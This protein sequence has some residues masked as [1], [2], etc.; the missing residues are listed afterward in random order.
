VTA[1]VDVSHSS[2]N[3]HDPTIGISDG[4]SFIGVIVYDTYANPCHI[5]EGDS[6]TTILKNINTINSPT[7]TSQCYFSEIKIQ[8]RP[9]E[10]W[11]SF[12]TEL[13]CG[14]TYVGNYQCLLDPMRNELDL[15]IYLGNNAN[16]NYHIKYVVVDVA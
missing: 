2:S 16:V 4:K 1:A 3:D 10:K 7:V 11:G 13:D 8:I 9:A 5:R 6:S 14:Y 12:H 15:E